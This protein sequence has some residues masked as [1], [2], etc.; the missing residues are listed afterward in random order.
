MIGRKVLF[1]RF[2]CIFTCTKLTD[3]PISKPNFSDNMP[4]I[5]IKY[6]CMSTNALDKFMACFD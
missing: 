1:N 4:C 5:V 3:W 6:D 2:I